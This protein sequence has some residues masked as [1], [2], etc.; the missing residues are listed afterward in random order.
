MVQK[1]FTLFKAIIASIL[2]KENQYIVFKSMNIISYVIAFTS[3]ILFYWFI[4]FIIKIWIGE[5]YLLLNSIEIT[6]S[7]QLFLTI[8]RISL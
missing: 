7:T 4:S 5:E 8:Y 3:S 2:N 6:F 1:L